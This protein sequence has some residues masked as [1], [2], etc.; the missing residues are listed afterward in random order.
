MVDCSQPAQTPPVPH[1]R[2]KPPRCNGTASTHTERQY[3]KLFDSSRYRTARLYDAVAV[4]VFLILLLILGFITL[5][6]IR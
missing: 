5:E 3:M 4:N 2:K 1:H 6:V